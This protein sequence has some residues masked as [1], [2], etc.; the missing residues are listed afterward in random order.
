MSNLGNGIGRSGWAVLLI[1]GILLV[2]AVTSALSFLPHSDDP[3]D[4]A[5]CHG[6]EQVL[7]PGHV[8][9]AGMSAETCIA[10]HQAGTALA[11]PSTILLDH[12]HLLSGV[13]CQTCHGDTQTPG[14]MTTEQCLGCHGPLEELAARTAD[15]RPT[16]PHSTPHGPTFAQCDLCHLVHKQS[17]N[18]CAQC[19]DF[20]YVVP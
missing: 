7:S 13:T 19:H 8:P 1:A 9:T 2:S 4:C 3:G 11:L 10:C 20:N 17:E 16:N 18:F 14:P 5:T 6:D 12:H 15:V